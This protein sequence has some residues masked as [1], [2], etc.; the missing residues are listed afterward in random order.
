MD[1]IDT[2]TFVRKIK[3]FPL[4][5]IYFITI[6]DPKQTPLWCKLGKINDWVRRYS[7]NYFIV[8]GTHGG[9]HF[10]IIAGVIPNKIPKPVKGIHFH[11]QDL[12]SK[13]ELYPRDEAVEE[14]IRQ[15]TDTAIY[16][17]HM[18]ALLLQVPDECRKISAMVKSYFK[19]KKAREARTRALTKKERDIEN[20][21]NYQFKNLEEPREALGRERYID[22]LLVC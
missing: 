4:S 3:K 6:R 15:D 8:K 2:E 9:T 14:S 17:T 20:L 1:T 21:I 13:K 16:L 11:I 5:R 12:T 18:N 22:Y 19:K 7:N 10:H